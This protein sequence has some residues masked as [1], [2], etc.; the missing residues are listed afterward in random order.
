MDHFAHIRYDCE[1]NTIIKQQTVEEHCR[2]CALYASEKSPEGMKKTARLAGLLHDMGKYT[3]EFSEYLIRGARE[4]NVRRGSVNHTFAGVRF[5]LERWRTGDRD[6]KEIACE[7]V[8]FAAGAHHGLF[9]GVG[10][11]YK[12]GYRHRLEKEGIPYNE[13]KENYLEKCADIGELDSLFEDA[14]AEVDKVW[15][16]FGELLVKQGQ[17]EDEGSNRYKQ[18]LFYASM[19]G[20]LLLSCVIDG[21]RRDTAEF[22]HDA[23]LPPLPQ[24]SGEMWARC[25]RRVEERL[26]SLP[27]KTEID[28][29]RRTI[30]RRCRDFKCEKKGIYRLSV[31]TGGGKTLA[32][33]RFALGAAAEYEKK[34]I[35]F[36]IP[37][38]S[39][40][41]QNA[42]VIRDYIADDSIILEHHSNVIRQKESKDELDENELLMETWDSPVIITTLVQ[43]LNALFDGKT[44]CIRRM[45]ALSDS[46]IVI[47]EV[48]SLP[49]NMIS[50]FNLALNFIAYV[51]NSIIVLC[52]ATQPC[53]EAV[54][55]PVIYGKTQD[56]MAYDPDLWKVFRRTR[57]IDRRIPGGYSAEGLADFVWE[58]AKTE[59]SALL[60]CNKKDEARAV[61]AALPQNKDVQRFHLSTSMCMAHRIK[62]MEKIN[63][64]LEAGSPV[65]CV[66]T[67]LVEAGVDFSFGCVIRVWAGMDNVI[68]SAGRCNRS[69]EMGSVKPVYIMNYKGEDLSRLKEIAA[70]QRAAATV[71]LKFAE[72]P[73]DFNDDLT[74]DEA[75][76]TYY[77]QLYKDMSNQRDYPVKEYNT[78][79]LEMLSANRAFAVH[80]KSA[81]ENVLVQAFAAAGEA[82]SVFDENT[83]DVLVPY[84]EGERLIA[85]LGS[86]EAKHSIGYRKSLL[87]QLK[88]FSISLYEYELKNLRD[89]SGI[90]PI[91]EYDNS[92][93]ALRSEFYN[94][95]T[96]VDIK[97]KTN[98]FS[99]V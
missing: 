31:P 38:L 74:S 45:C 8:A 11:D 5:A 47:D 82:F 23:V 95:E 51:C 65:I 87:A 58:C 61:F 34:R 41:E 29:T 88:P 4:E 84:G 80:C 17:S 60:I 57:V 30:S 73:E 3:A 68:Q 97:G 43:L 35:F 13:A 89:A 1:N 62:T 37:L 16:Q 9:D 19:L 14:Y 77:R 55:H 94:N 21:D 52:S 93:L 91:K 90:Y 71:L 99:E 76:Q 25:L 7:L 69:G 22:M 59:G 54:E 18:C 40:L 2:K 85:E 26:E 12:N 39:V 96:G 36:V 53:L 15:M 24:N 86:D 83:R 44:S 48:Q 92:V 10:P 75:I 32:G 6:I 79:L 70:S 78:T 28:L 27:A 49:R 42:D 66:S 63:A 50:L 81:E 72:N 33:L 64:A 67:Q 98:I 46:V 56:I 20:R